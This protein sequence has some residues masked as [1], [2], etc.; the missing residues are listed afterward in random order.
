MGIIIIAFTDHLNADETNNPSATGPALG[1]VIEQVHPRLSNLNS[2]KTYSRNTW[3]L[4][5]GTETIKSSS[6]HFRRPLIADSN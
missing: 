4:N 1:F 5:I 3:K 6:V 2:V